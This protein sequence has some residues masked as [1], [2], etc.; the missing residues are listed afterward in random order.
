MTPPG[1]PI[2][3]VLIASTLE[4][5]ELTSQNRSLQVEQLV[6]QSTPQSHPVNKRGLKSKL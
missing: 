4:T 6:C 3:Q 1:P 2:P 5:V